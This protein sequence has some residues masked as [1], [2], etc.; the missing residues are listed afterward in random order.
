MLGCTILGQKSL[1]TLAFLDRINNTFSS[2]Q[3]NCIAKMTERRPGHE[4]DHIARSE[5]V[6]MSRAG[7]SSYEIARIT[8]DAPSTIQYTLKQAPIRDENHSLPRGRPTK[9]DAR[10]D[11]KLAR[12]TTTTEEQRRKPLEQLRNKETPQISVRTV[13]RRLKKVVIRNRLQRR[14]RS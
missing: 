6:G 7:H 3:H 8:G 13:K 10:E 14:S 9:T 4:L 2:S 11:R 5:I 1:G 12:A